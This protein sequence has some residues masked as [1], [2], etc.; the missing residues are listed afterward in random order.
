MIPWLTA[1]YPYIVYPSIHCVLRVDAMD[2]GAVSGSR[3]HWLQGG[4]RRLEAVELI[5]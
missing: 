5:G 1:L 2:A 3:R 4:W